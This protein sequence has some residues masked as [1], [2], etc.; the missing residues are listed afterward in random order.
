MICASRLFAGC[1][2]NPP[3]LTDILPEDKAPVKPGFIVERATCK[4]GNQ[5]ATSTRQHWLQPALQRGYFLLKLK[6][7]FNLDF[8]ISGL[9]A[10]LISSA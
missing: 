10:C 7:G 2:R 3:S 9:S 1:V 6:T 5:A 4:G 8:M